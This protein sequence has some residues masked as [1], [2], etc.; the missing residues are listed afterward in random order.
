[1]NYLPLVVPVAALAVLSAC[2]GNAG[3]PGVTHESGASSAVVAA[4]RQATPDVVIPG[5][6]FEYG[7]ARAADGAMTVTRLADGA[8]TTYPA[9]AAT[10]AF[11]DRMVSLDADGIAGQAYRLYQAA[12]DRQPD[13]SGLGF[14]INTL[15]HGTT[16]DDV[17]AQ[18]VDSA[19]FKARYGDVDDRQ[20]IELVYQNVLHRSPDEGGFA[21]WLNGLRNGLSRPALLRSFSES[22]ENKANLA[23]A[24]GKGMAYFSYPSDGGSASTVFGPARHLVPATPSPDAAAA[25]AQLSRQLSSQEPPRQAVHPEV[26]GANQTVVIRSFKTENGTFGPLVLRVLGD[27]SL[28]PLGTPAPTTE[29]PVASYDS[30]TGIL[31]MDLFSSGGN[32]HADARWQL[33]DDGSLRLVTVRAPVFDDYVEVLP[34]VFAGGQV[35]THYSL[36]TSIQQLQQ[37]AAGD[38]LMLGNTYWDFS[39]T[40]LDRFRK[41]PQQMLRWDGSRFQDVS[42]SLVGGGIPHMNQVESEKM[43]ADFNGDGRLDVVLGGNGPDGEGNPGEPSYALLSAGAQD[44]TLASIPNN[45]RRAGTHSWVHGG[46]ALTLRDK[47]SPVAFIGDFSFGPSYLVEFAKDGTAAKLE[48]RLP[49]Y[50]GQSSSALNG[51]FDSADFPVLAALGVDLDN[52]GADELVLGSSYSYSAADVAPHLNDIHTMVL[53]QDAGGSFANGA[54]LILPNGPFAK[55]NCFQ[56]ADCENLTVKQIASAD[57]NRDGLADL[58]ITHHRYGARYASATQL[59]INKGNLQFADETNGWFGSALAFEGNWHIHSYPY[60]LNG[61]GCPDVVLRGDEINGARPKVFISDCKG[62]MTDHSA[63]FQ[64]LLPSGSRYMHGGVPVSLGGKPAILLFNMMGSTARFSAVRFIYPLP[65][66]GGR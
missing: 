11:A 36:V 18:F 47:A 10:F 34:D 5:Y 7:I 56:V 15:Q 50:I 8:T 40:G 41:G 48:G 24:I 39:R 64:Q 13:Q 51:Y 9:S 55:R 25:S 63:A 65:A 4:L 66:A 59:L 3:Q 16:L 23:P 28:V 2:G 21:F 49:A 17:S 27:G 20:F 52:D 61:D 30:G 57:F 58:L 19:E 29:R 42:A 54:P 53:R 6:R 22:A 14:W 12:F 62:R 43:V 1:M 37:G 33:Q 31:R 45:A 38:L 32:H 46:A 26:D 35:D 44:F 60:D